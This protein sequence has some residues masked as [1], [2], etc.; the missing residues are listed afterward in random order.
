MRR[1]ILKHVG[2]KKRL[3]V[4]NDNLLAL[5]NSRSSTTARVINAEGNVYAPC[6]KSE[7]GKNPIIVQKSSYMID[8]CKISELV[9]ILNLYIKLK[10]EDNIELLKNVCVNLLM[11]KEKL[12]YHDI[13]TLLKKFSIIKC[14]NYFLFSYFKD[15]LMENLHTLTCDNLVDIYFSFT[16]LNYFH[17]NFFFLIEKKLF[18]NFHMLDLKKLI[19]LIQCFNKKKLITKNYL[20]ILLYS[21]SKNVHNF[22]TF[23]ISVIFR[24]F[25]NFQ[26][27]NS[28][29]I[30]S[31]IHHFNQNINLDDDPKHVALFYNFLSYVHKK[32]RKG[33]QYL[34]MEKELIGV[35]KQ[36]KMC[37]QE[38]DIPRDTTF[39]VDKKGGILCNVPVRVT[40][41]VQGEMQGEKE[42]TE[43]G[44]LKKKLYELERDCLFKS[45]ELE[46]LKDQTNLLK[47]NAYNLNLMYSVNNTLKNIETITR[48][49]LKSMSAESLCIVS[50][51][52]SNISKN[53]LL[54]EKIAEEVGKQSTKLSPML[55]SF[56][57]LS[58]SKASHKHG[59]LIYYSLQFFYKYSKF[60][61]IN[62]VGLMC[63]GLHNFAIKENE[64]IHALNEFV[65]DN[66]SGC[67]DICQEKQ[68]WGSSSGESNI[69][70]GSTLVEG[71]GDCLN[72]D[73]K[74]IPGG[75]NSVEKLFYEVERRIDKNIE[76]RNYEDHFTNL[77]MVHL[78]EDKKQQKDTQKLGGYENRAYDKFV[79][80]SY[81]DYEN[82]KKNNY[83]PNN[84]YNIKTGNSVYINNVI[85]ILEYYAL[86]LVSVNNILDSFCDIFLKSN[87]N[88]ILYARIFYSFYTLQYQGNKVYELIEKFNNYQP[89]YQFMYNEK[90]MMK[91][92][93]SLVFYY[94]NKKE[95]DKMG[96][97]YFYVMSKSYFSFIFNFSKYILTF[98]FIKNNNY[99]LHNFLVHIGDISLGET[100]YMFLHKPNNLY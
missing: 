3:V 40:A 49:K 89:L 61:N 30:S 88:Y 50:S 97:I 65:L 34:K 4:K 27:S 72:Y 77:K 29:L 23:Q 81:I 69:R 14:K 16:N 21:I 8:S 98:L 66:I 80:F 22:N 55:V 6:G 76:R 52:L 60:F 1:A 64:F 78:E 10:N 99:V 90:H 26:I 62:E 59:S 12:R 31:L 73:R 35:I 100:D 85:Y 95:E 5:L 96:D 33:Y 47:R 91:L 19:Y 48:K 54:L 84:L 74:D 11:N 2:S 70:G 44:I 39:D 67:S 63:K 56:F 17:Y 82:I 94:E 87:L 36:F 18:H 13:L 25:K 42:N 9:N 93:Q 86:N 38:D 71:I 79:N 75:D 7:E 57:L 83:Y 41:N 20:T 28:V 15:I 46:R 32:C 51:S 45:T 53:K 68:E 43:N 24:F 92:L 58:F 37:Y